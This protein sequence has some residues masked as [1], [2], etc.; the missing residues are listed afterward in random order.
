MELTY[1]Q[2]AL[3]DI[4]RA[5]AKM[6]GFYKEGSRAQRNH[7]PGNIW[8]GLGK[9]KKRRIWPDLPIDNEGYVIYPEDRY[10][11]AALYKQILLDARRGLTL[12]QF[13]NK[14]SPPN[15][16]DTENYIKF[17]EKRLGVGRNDR[18]MDILNKEGVSYE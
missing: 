7:N 6:E 1:K 8:D 11:W 16:N 18:L 2:K 12:E 4:A 15:E 10:G 3:I 14:F 13:I 9:G 5:I 17:M